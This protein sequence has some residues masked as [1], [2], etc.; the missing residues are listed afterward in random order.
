M[1]FLSPGWLWLFVVVALLIAGY[2][3]AQFA[4][5]RYAAPNVEFRPAA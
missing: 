5:R 2:V 4:R 1:S 3:A